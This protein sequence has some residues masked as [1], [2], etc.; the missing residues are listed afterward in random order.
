MIPGACNAPCRGNWAEVGGCGG[1]YF[2][3]VYTNTENNA[4]FV[5]PAMVSSVGQW[6]GLG[7]Y[8]S[9]DE[10]RILMQD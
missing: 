1:Q 6:D 9:V 3:S 10:Q 2:A 4:N 8:K 5:I 7:C